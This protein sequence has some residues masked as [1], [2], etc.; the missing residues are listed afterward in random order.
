MS[1][2]KSCHMET[3]KHAA[4]A[5]Q[6]TNMTAEDMIPDTVDLLHDPQFWCLPQMHEAAPPDGSDGGCYPLYL[7]TQGHIVGIWR[8]WAVVK[9]MVA[10]Q[11]YCMPT[12][13]AGCSSKKME[14]GDTDTGGSVSSSSSVTTSSWQELPATA[15]CYA[16]W[17]SGIVYGDHEEAKMVFM[18]A[19]M[20]GA[21]PKILSTADYDEVQAFC[22]G[23]YW[24]ED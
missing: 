3:L 19:L 2:S 11:K 1:S 8:S 21:K 9:A 12:L 13:P 7:V 10:L 24:I 17:R 6:P 5:L 22:D 16:I 15:R 23:I 18:A 14:D 20:V 4:V